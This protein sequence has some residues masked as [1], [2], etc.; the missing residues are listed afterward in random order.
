MLKRI[1]SYMKQ[2]KKYACL[3]LLC[4]AVEAVL[5]LMVP[6]IMADLIDN[7]VANGDTAYIYTKGLQMA[8]CAVLALILGIG[9]ARFSALAGQ[10][11]GA[12]IR[13]AEYE[14]LQSYSFANIDHFRV[15]SLVTR[16]TSDVTNIQNSVSTG[17]RPF[18]RSPVML[19]FASSVAFTINRT[20]AFVFF[21]AL[22]ILAVLLIIIIMNVRPLYGRMQTAIDLVNTS[23]QENLTAIRVVKAY[24]RGDY[25]VAKFE[26]VNANLKKESEKAFGIAVLNMPAMQ[27]V[28]YGTII[29]ILFI[30]GHLINAGQLKIGELTSFLSYV[31][32]ILNSLMMMSNVFLM[33]TRSLASASRIVEVLDEKIDITDE[34]AEDISVKKGSIEFDHVWFKYKKEAKEYVLSD[35]SFNIEAGQTIG[36]IGQ[37]GSAKTTLV[38][39]IPRL[40]DATKGTVRIDGIDV[41]KYPMRHLRDAIAVVLQKNTLFSGSLLSNLYWGNENASM[42]EINEACHIACVDEFLDRLPQGYDTDMGQG[43]VNVS[44]G[45]KQR[46]CIARA[47]LKK[48]KVLILDDSTSAV[49]TATEAKIR[50]G[51]AKKLP[52]MTK[53]VIAQRISSVKHADQIIIL[54]RGKVAAIGTHETLLANNRIYQ[55]IYESQKEGVDL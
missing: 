34:Q 12:N 16:L 50:E 44:G 37:T 9:S 46:I 21:V 26:E 13:Q 8:G 52:D 53:I 42:E 33:M 17:M 25:E 22:P 51:L 11:L 38:S 20:L 15:S 5:E 18:G 7:G 48:P 39:L 31:L 55:E 24:V 1:F 49:D 10:G 19:I 6:M 27:F 4:I 23:I 3:A 41:K 47:I 36:I 35:V 14:K 32:L 54:D 29:S 45:Q 30:G 43:G 2:Y 28:M 40:Y